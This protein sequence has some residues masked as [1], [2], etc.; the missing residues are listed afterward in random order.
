MIRNFIALA[1]LLFLSSNILFAEIIK[2]VKVTGNKRLSTS[3]IEV[4]GQIKKNSS[5]DQERINVLI[6]D[7]YLLFSNNLN[8]FSPTSYLI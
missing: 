8:I 1:S 6:K 2:D 4:I 3:T 7:L 5:Y